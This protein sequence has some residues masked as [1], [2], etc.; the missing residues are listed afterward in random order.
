MKTPSS[1]FDYRASLGN[2]SWLGVSPI[3]QNSPQEVIACLTLPNLR[4]SRGGYVRK[5]HLTHTYLAPIK[6]TSGDSLT[7]PGKN[8][9]TNQNSYWISK[10]IIKSTKYV[11]HYVVAWRFLEILP[12]TWIFQKWL[13]LFWLSVWSDIF[14]LSA[15]CTEKRIGCACAHKYDQ[16]SLLWVRNAWRR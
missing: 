7:K 6:T 9:F 12:K 3:L 4:D 15:R 8:T 10:N 11:D 5:P 13:I 1:D 16:A 14:A 2:Y